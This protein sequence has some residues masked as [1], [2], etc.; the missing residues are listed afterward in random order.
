MF[1]NSHRQ[2][3]ENRSLQHCGSKVKEGVYVADL[4]FRIDQ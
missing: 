3:E 1:D 2:N 4:F